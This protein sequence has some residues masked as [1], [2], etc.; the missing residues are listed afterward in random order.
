MGRPLDTSSEPESFRGLLLRHRGRTGLIQRDVAA[1]AGVSRGAI[2]D[3][4]SGVNYPSAKR[5]QA[6]IRVLLEADGL[7]AGQEESEAR[8]LWAAAEREA[9]RMNT[10]FDE[11]WFASLP[12]TRLGTPSSLAR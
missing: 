1:R 3:W 2:Q 11:E 5:L 12:A 8:T 6:L 9:P 4:E 7:T 10:P